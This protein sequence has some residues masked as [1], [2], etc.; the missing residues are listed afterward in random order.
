MAHEIQVRMS[1]DASLDKVGRAIKIE[2]WVENTISDRNQ[3]PH[4][5]TSIDGDD[6]IYF[7]YYFDTRS[8]AKPILRKISE[9][10]VEQA[11]WGLVNYR[12]NPIEYRSNTFQRDGEYYNPELETGLRTDPQIRQT[13]HLALRINSVDYLIN[14]DEY[15]T[16]AQEIVLEGHDTTQRYISLVG[17][18]TGLEVVYGDVSGNPTKPTLPNDSVE[19]ATIQTYPSEIAEIEEYTQYSQYERTAWETEYEFGDVPEQW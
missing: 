8:D 15:S 1:L 7:H 13:D 9:G 14:N 17:T 11:D 2:E 16:D 12:K 19:F 4:E 10:I 3:E 18:E 5:R 6:Y